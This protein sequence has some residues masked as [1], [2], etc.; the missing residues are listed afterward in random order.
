MN[1]KLMQFVIKQHKLFPGLLLIIFGLIILITYFFPVLILE[2]RF[3]FKNIFYKE[4]KTDPVKTSSQLPFIPA[5]NQFSVVI[6]KIEINSKVISDIDPYNKEEYQKALSLGVVH[7][8]GSAYPNNGGNVFIFAHSTDS[9]ANVTRYNAIFYL[10]DK[11]EVGGQIYLVYNGKLY[12]Y[13]VRGKKVINPDEIEYLENSNN[14]EKT[15][16]LM[17]C[18][19]AGTTLKRLLVIAQKVD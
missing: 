16:T 8:K 3:R 11:L 17:T 9:S 18:W 7:A 5:D 2:T 1:F 15:L 4:T 14:K 13:K 19:P 10:L 6:P 12:E